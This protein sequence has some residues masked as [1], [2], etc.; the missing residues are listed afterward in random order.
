MLCKPRNV[1]YFGELNERTNVF[2]QLVVVSSDGCHNL[3]VAKACRI[4]KVCYF[5]QLL[6]FAVLMGKRS[7]NGSAPP[8]RDIVAINFLTIYSLPFR[9][10]ILVF[11]SFV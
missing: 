4:M 3:R 9:D 11:W 5:V 10:N 7:T 1:S 8:C 6:L 2:S